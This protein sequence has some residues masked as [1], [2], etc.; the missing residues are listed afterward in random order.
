[1]SLTEHPAPGP[2]GFFCN[3]SSVYWNP[4]TVSPFGSQGLREGSGELKMVTPTTFLARCPVVLGQGARLLGV[5][6][7]KLFP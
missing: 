1:M 7:R 2:G 5:R 6:L 3:F 4:G